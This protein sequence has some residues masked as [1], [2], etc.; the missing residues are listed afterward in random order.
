MT[1]TRTESLTELFAALD[2]SPDPARHRRLLADWA[3]GLPGVT[4]F[5]VLDDAPPLPS[6]P[7]EPRFFADH[8]WVPL[9]VKAAGGSLAFRLDTLIARELWAEHG[10]EIRLAASKFA[11]QVALDRLSSPAD[12]LPA[13]LLGLLDPVQRDLLETLNLPLYMAQPDGSILFVNRPFLW[14]FGFPSFDTFLLRQHHFFDAPS[15]SRQLAQLR[16]EGALHGHTLNVTHADGR[17]LTVRDYATYK[18]ERVLGVLVDVT[19]SV[20]L[21]NEMREALEIQSLLNEKILSTATVLQKTQTT[22]IRALARLA[23]YRDQET[24][25][26]LSRIC[27]YAGLLAKEVWRRQPY[28][29]TIS[30]QYVEDIVL[31][32]LLHDVGKVAVPDSILRKQGRL[33]PS[34]WEVMKQHTL[35]GHQLLSQADKELGE[36][37]F[38]TLASQIAL[39][40]HERWDGTGYPHG[41]KGEKIPLSARIEAIG[42]VYDALTSVRPYKAAWSHEEA[43]AEIL[44]QRGRHFDPVLVDILLEIQDQFAAV[45]AQFAGETS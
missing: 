16:H 35:W 6:G 8:L 13:E 30:E 41:L 29:F 26:H 43:I 40:H 33:D 24:G 7:A 22:S 42:D 9:P 12:P 23:E 10:V 21:N 27:E 32:S 38:L 18:R 2:R 36:Q 44:A 34:E 31:S 20:I 15:R 45:K 14:H 3:R 19:E 11:D 37:S 17:I 39:H 25:G 5:S 28:E 4:G 1:L